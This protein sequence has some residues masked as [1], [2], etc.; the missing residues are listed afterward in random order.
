M[1]EGT[2]AASPDAA[3]VPAGGETITMLVIAGRRLRERI[4]SSLTPIGMT[5]RHVSA[6]GHLKRQNDLSY[7]DL[8][9]RAGVTAQSMRATVAHLQQLGTISATTPGQGQRARLELTSTGHDLLQRAHRI[10]AETE[11]RT[12]GSLDDNT[13]QV[14]RHALPVVIAQTA[15]TP[16]PG[17][18]PGR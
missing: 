4:D 18:R 6:L 15:D 8:A 3:S 10:I 7:S 16:P 9:R 2:E 1:T 5:M 14:L 11:A 12:L 13:R 17:T